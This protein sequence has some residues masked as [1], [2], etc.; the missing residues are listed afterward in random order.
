MHL[1]SKF[2]GK[3]FIQLKYKYKLK[4]TLLFWGSYIC[5][6]HQVW[7]SP[8]VPVGYLRG[9]TFITL[10]FLIVYLRVSWKT[11]LAWF[12]ECISLLIRPLCWLKKTLVNVGTIRSITLPPTSLYQREISSTIVCICFGFLFFFFFWHMI[13]FL[14]Q[15]RVAS[16]SMG[17]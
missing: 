8:H 14:T 1:H 16:I 11:H 5:T 2:Y 4:Y 6:P 13:L 10:L 3:C 15:S 9:N 17:K 7:T 12:S